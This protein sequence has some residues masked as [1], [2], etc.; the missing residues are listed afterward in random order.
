MFSTYKESDVT[1]L[2]KDITNLVVPL[3]TEEREK[4]IQQGVHYSEMLPIE[5]V[6]SQ[7]YLKLFF[8]GLD[9]YAG[10]T[11]RAVASAAMKIREK[12]N[13]RPV[14][15]SLARAGTPVG[16]LIK[17]YLDAR[18][19]TDVPHYSI[20][21]IRG[22]G[23]DKNAM[24][25]I[26]SRYE[27]ERLQF[28]DGWTGK[29][30]IQNEVNAAMKDYPG[31]DP[32]LAVLSDPAAIAGIAG[33]Y[34]DFFIANSC[35]NSTVSGLLSRTFCD[36]VIIGENDYHG[37]AFYS[38]LAQSDLT[39][40]F[41]DRIVSEFTFTETVLRENKPKTSGL[42]EVTGICSA[43]GVNDVNKVKPGIGEATRVLLR[44]VPWKILVRSLDDEAHLGH[45]YQ[46]AKEKGVTVEDYPLQNYRACGIIKTMA[47]T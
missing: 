41:I 23:I 42:D 27:P 28:V 33:T 20:S 30:A 6:P 45:I 2:L 38:E 31:V 39:Y 18:F 4:R 17:R 43:F 8:D 22:K 24:R 36:R 5:Y 1:L 10:I 7:D 19:D 25:T 15:V 12:K 14:L 46:L 47:D 3:P 9:R 11:A 40:R 35:L 34:D 37:A 16:I 44:R 21:V 26:L 13:G 32:G 29:G